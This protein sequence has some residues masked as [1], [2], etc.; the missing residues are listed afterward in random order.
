MV[1]LVPDIAGSVQLKARLVDVVVPLVREAGAAGGAD[2]PSD[3]MVMFTAAD[4]L[5]WPLLSV[6]LAVMTWVPTLKPE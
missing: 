2:V 1:E 3:A 4:E 6:A 5:L